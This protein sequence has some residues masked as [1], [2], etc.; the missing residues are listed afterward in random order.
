MIKYLKSEISIVKVD[1]ET[2][3]S[4]T[5]FNDPLAKRIVHQILDESAFGL[6]TVIK[7]EEGFF[8]EVTEEE[9]LAKKE[10]VKSIITSF[11]F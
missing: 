4:L 9:F 11:G 5:I 2:K 1:T 8:T 7:V 6:V 3:E 10:E